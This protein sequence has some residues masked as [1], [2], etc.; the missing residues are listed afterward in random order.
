METVSSRVEEIRASA[1][2]EQLEG[3]LADLEL[4]ASDSTF[5]DDPAKAQETL[6]ALTDVQDKIKLL[7]GFKSQVFILWLIP[8]N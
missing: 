8:T 4:K 5:W 6:L 1:G 2:L 7:N 3:E